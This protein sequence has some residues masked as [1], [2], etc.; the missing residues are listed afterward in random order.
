M[1]MLA[2][3]LTSQTGQ[4]GRSLLEVM[5]SI[6]V[7]VLLV[8]PVGAW[9]ILAMEN[10]GPTATRFSESSQARIA[11]TYLS[12]DVGSA[13]LV[14]VAD[15]GPEPGCGDDSGDQVFLQLVDDAD[16]SDEPPIR[17]VYVTNSTDGIASVWRRQCST[18]DTSVVQAQTHV[19]R[20]IDTSPGNEPTAECAGT[21]CRQVT[22][23]ATLEGGTPVNVRAMRRATLDASFLGDDDNFRPHARAEVI[24]QSGSRPNFTVVL[25]SSS[26]SDIDG[27]IEARNWSVSPTPVSLTPHDDGTATAVFSAVGTYTATLTVT[28]DDGEL[29]TPAEVDIEVQNQ[30]PVASVEVTSDRSGAVVGPST[31]TFTFDASAS[32]DPDGDGIASWN[33]DFGDGVATLSGQGTPTASVTFDTEDLGYREIKVTV[34]DGL[35]ATGVDRTVIQ[36]LDPSGSEPDTGPIEVSTDGE[37]E[38]GTPVDTPGRLPRAGTV[39]PGRP[40]VNVTFSTSTA[41]PFTWE[42]RRGATVVESSTDAT[43]ARSFGAGDDG[44]WTIALIP[45]GGAEVTKGFRLNAAPSAQF[46]VSGS[47]DAPTPRSF[48]SGGSG[49]DNGIVA[50]SWNFGFFDYWTSTL[51]D[52]NQIFDHPGLYDVVLAVTDDDGAT[53]F[54][55]SQV[56]IAGVV[57]APATGSFVGNTYTWPAV[58]GIEGYQVHL[59]V[60]DAPGCSSATGPFDY[61]VGVDPAPSLPTAYAGCGVTARHRVKVS[62]TWG[63]YSAV[64]QRP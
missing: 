16:E 5:I 25:D 23:T 32:A 55:S 37:G 42:L 52:P 9:M 17:T 44:D 7:A 2:R 28:D 57:P 61:T 64:V 22:F 14:R 33:W 38:F 49:D 8:G 1:R 48:D 27:T 45:D 51:A 12:R 24:A 21:A 11:N 29:S 63:P 20:G 15:F 47:G 60:T 39:G 41:P 4:A 13:E 3:R 6:G 53:S 54:V 36:L 35:G 31:H 18:A 26:S 56:A 62:G 46:T 50:Y 59:E 10:Q 30:S 19:L 34:T 43:F 58:A 40:A